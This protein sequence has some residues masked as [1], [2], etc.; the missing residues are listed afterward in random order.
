MSV[1]ALSGHARLRQYER[2]F[3]RHRRVSPQRFRRLFLRNAI[4]CAHSRERDT[5]VTRVTEALGQRCASDSR[6]AA[7]ARLLLEGDRHSRP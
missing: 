4:A 6:A 7:R 1:R 2:A 3:A 5:R